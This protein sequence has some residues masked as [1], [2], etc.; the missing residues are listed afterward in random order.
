MDGSE[1]PRAET[2]RAFAAELEAAGLTVA[3]V[4]ERRTTVEAHGILS[5]AGKRGKKRRARI[6][7]V[8]ATLILETWLYGP[9]R[10]DPE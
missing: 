5:E 8:A 2:S 3:F 1:G 4:D 9:G 7:A 10:R 6:D